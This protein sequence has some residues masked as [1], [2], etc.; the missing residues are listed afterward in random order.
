MKVEFIPAPAFAPQCWHCKSKQKQEEKWG[1]RLHGVFC[2]EA[3]DKAEWDVYCKQHEVIAD[4]FRDR[5]GG[6]R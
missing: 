5:A 4:M 3:C 1:Y 6:P 2:S